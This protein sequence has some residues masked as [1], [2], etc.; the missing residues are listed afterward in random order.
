MGI[1]L[2]FVNSKEGIVQSVRFTSMLVSIPN[3]WGLKDSCFED[4]DKLYF[5]GFTLPGSGPGQ[6]CRWI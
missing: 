3:Y 2:L 5:M 4:L 6:I 1:L